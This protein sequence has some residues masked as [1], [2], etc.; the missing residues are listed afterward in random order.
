MTALNTQSFS[1]IVSN[2]VAA[3]QGAASQLIDTSIG[4]ILRAASEAAA[5]VALWLQGLALQIAATSR[6][7][8]SS[9]TDVDSFGADFGFTRLPAKPS[10]GQV[11]L[12]RF[13][14]TA[15]ATI[16]VGTVVQ[17]QDGTQQFQLTA[18]ATEAAFNAT[19]NAYVIP[20]STASITASAQAL[21][22]GAASNV[23]AGLI[24]TLGSSMPGVDTVTNAASFT[25][26]ADA[27][28]DAAYKNRF[29]RQRSDRPWSDLF[30]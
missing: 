30:R 15:P 7:S 19:L 11:T 3:V 29:C 24:N 28:T 14:T 23:A 27:E 12:G 4:S 1:T 18:D 8:T 22:A 20:S 2:M 5:G 9:G 10:N 17:T 16:A 25:N 13:T 6:L 21:T 26:G